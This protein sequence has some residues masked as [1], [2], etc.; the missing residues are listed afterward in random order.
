[1]FIKNVKQHNKY[2]NITRIKVS[3]A[4]KWCK[5]LGNCNSCNIAIIEMQKNVQNK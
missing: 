2:E 4:N 1:M 5:M 3:N